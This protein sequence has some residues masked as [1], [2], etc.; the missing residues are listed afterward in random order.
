LAID[1]TISPD[2]KLLAYASDRAGGSNLDIWVQPIN[3]G[4]PLRL[5]IFDRYRQGGS[6]TS[7]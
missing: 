7:N 3:G 1:P 2:G 6:V 5:T 4:T